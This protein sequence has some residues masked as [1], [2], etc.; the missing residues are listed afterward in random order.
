MTEDFVNTMSM[1]AAVFILGMSIAVGLKYVNQMKN[2]KAS[3]KLAEDNWDGIG[4]YKNELPIGWA[5]SFLGT[6]IWAMWYWTTGYPVNAYSQIGEWNEEVSEYQQKFESK[7]AGADASTLKSMGESLFLVQCAP[8]HG[9]TA[10]GMGGKAADLTV[11]GHEK[12]IVDT[13]VNGS[14]GLNYPMGEMPAGLVDAETAKAIAAYVMAEVSEKKHTK[15]PELVETGKAMWSV[16][17]GCHGQDGAGMGGMAPDLTGYGTPK[18]VSAVLERGKK[19][20]IGHMPSFRGRFSDIQEK[21]VGT[22][23]LSLGQ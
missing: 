9:E 15:N 1:L 16:C 10:D 12:A 11:W 22:Y 5:L 7:W 21:A 17:A 19:G 23:I 13:I 18:F 8:C 4:E 6:I 14:K 3:G 2:D 20:M